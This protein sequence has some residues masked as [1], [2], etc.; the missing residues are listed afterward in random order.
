MRIE[1]LELK[2]EFNWEFEL[3]TSGETMHTISK[4]GSLHVSN[5]SLGNF[6]DFAGLNESSDN[7]AGFLD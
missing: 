6:L 7:N 1:A 3:D 5:D 4:H 2:L